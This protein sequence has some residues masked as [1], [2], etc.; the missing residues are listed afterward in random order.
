MSIG[1]LYLFKVLAFIPPYKHLQGFIRFQC[2]TNIQ[3]F[4]PYF[5]ITIKQ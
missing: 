5:Y 3:A 4:S 1:P 2:E